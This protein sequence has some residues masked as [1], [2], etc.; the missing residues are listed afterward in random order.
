MGLLAI[1]VFSSAARGQETGQ[2][3]GTVTDPTSAVVPNATVAIKHLGTNAIRTVTTSAT[4]AYLVTGLQPATYELTITATGFHPYSTRVEVTVEG[5]VTVDTKLSVTQENTSVEVTAEGGT[6]AN[7]QTQELSQIVNATQVEQMPSLTRNPYDFVALAGNVS[8]GDS[9]NSGDSRNASNGNSQNATT[10][11]VGFNING[12]RSSGTEILLDG[13]ENISVFSDNVGVYIPQDATQEFRVQTSNYEPQ[14]GRASG[15]IVNVATKSGTNAFHGV[16][17][18]FNR[19]SAYTSNTV[20]NAQE[21]LPKGAYTR[22]QFGFAVGGPILKNKLFFFGSTEWTRVRSSAISTAA[23][24]TPQFLS[25]AAANTAAFFS[26]YSG[27]KNFNFTNTYTAGQLG[28][29]GIPASIPAFGTVAYTAPVNAGGSVPQ[30]TYNIVGRFDYNVSDRTLV[31]FRYANYNEI[32]ESGAAFASP[33]NQYNVAS[34]ALSTAYLLS[35]TH[36]FNPY[37]SESTKLSFSRFNAPLA[38]NTALQNTPT[39]IV[40]PNAQ[41]PGTSTFIQLPGFYD[42]NPAV[43]G[44]PFG[45]P[46]NTTQ[47]NQDLTLQKG[48][49]SMQ[50]GG[51]ILYIQANN[52]FGAYAQ[53]SEQVGTT[54]SAGLNGLVTGDL[55]QFQAA[56]NPKGALPCVVDPYTGVFTQTPGCSINLPATPPAFARSNRFHDWAVYAQDSFRVKPKFT[57]NYGVR[58]EYYGVQ[59]NNNPNLDSNFY[60]APGVANYYQS[61]RSGQVYTAPTSPIGKLWNPQYGTVS[62]RVGFALDIFGDGTTSFR[63][64]YGISYERNFGNVT[65]NV[66]Q[67]PPAY[68]VIVINNTL[69][70]NSNS[71]P[72]SG[73]SGSVPLPPTSLRNVDE[74]IRTAQTQF[75]DAALERQL[76]RNTVLS[77]Q[78]AGARGLHLYDIKNINTLGGGNVLLGDPTSD[79]QGNTGLT[80]LINQYSNINNRGSNGDSYYESMNIQFQTTNYRNSGLSLVANYT[81]AHQLDDLSTAFSETNNAFGLGYTQPFN[82]GFDHGAGDLDLHQRLV[83]AP[84]YRTPSIGKSRLMNEALGGWQVTGIYTVRTGAPFSYFDTTNNATGYQIARYTP[85]AGVIPQHTFTKIPSGVTGGGLNSYVIGN[86]PAAVSFGNPALFGI[87]DWGPFPATMI[88]RN[89]F[90]GPGAWTFDASVSKIFPI[91]EQVN[92]EFRAE[93]FDVLNH[94]NLFIQEGLNDVANV[95]DGVPVPITASK[96]GIGNNGGANDERR[97]GQF[98][99]KINF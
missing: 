14:Y 80:R 3:S 11:G 72:L 58:Y 45:G 81:Y 44:L 22:N 98:A 92:V 64:G 86:I 35:A 13:V 89:S 51:Q 5:R 49:H 53:A 87:S 99:L 32:D 59:H 77:L 52:A 18:E 10:R 90:R 12:Q 40:F 48:K 34:S 76:A 8:A 27:G 21:G 25:L 7:T 46:Q 24:P 66:I 74:N 54:R 73:S 91:H 88:A 6:Q 71:G 19:L 60:Y 95:G 57:F 42:F 78:Y 31:F 65:F 85:A 4:G 38:Y 63:G 84:L 75:W 1:L 56:V 39:L 41:L 20:T 37:L 23:V 93:G 17:W 15:G 83:I 47:I 26:A 28:I 68:A 29:A 94:H 61:V 70:T 50:F 16:V 96:G 36:I 67:N 9:T 33:Y 2:I 55:F 79:S 62:P 69:I 43:G 30:N 97:F 82:P